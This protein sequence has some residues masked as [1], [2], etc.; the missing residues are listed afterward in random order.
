MPVGHTNPRVWHVQTN[1]T[2]PQILRLRLVDVPGWHATIDGK[3]LQLIRFAGVMLQAR[4]PPGHHTIEL[5]YW[6]DTFTAG[7]VLAMVAVIALVLAL[8]LGHHR[9]TRKV[10]SVQDEDKDEILPVT[11]DRLGSADRDAGGGDTTLRPFPAPGRHRARSRRARSTASAR[12]R[13][14]GR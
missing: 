3:P 5:Q 1:G 12:R 14:S 10:P 7:I 6:P 2:T 13:P 9:R 4:I 11:T 8:A